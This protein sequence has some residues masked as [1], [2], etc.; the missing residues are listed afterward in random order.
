ML[1]LK[2]KGYAPLQDVQAA[3]A[4]RWVKAVNA[5]G[6]FG[7]WPYRLVKMGDINGVVADVARGTGA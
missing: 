1:I 3:A 7:R 4:E 6:A 5:D 2:T